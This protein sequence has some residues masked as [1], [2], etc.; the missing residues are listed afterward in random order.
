M[1]WYFFVLVFPSACLICSTLM[2]SGVHPDMMAWLTASFESDEAITPWPPSHSLSC[3]TLFGFSSPVRAFA[4][5]I[6]AC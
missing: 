6:S 1:A 3:E 4:S 5:L 2:T